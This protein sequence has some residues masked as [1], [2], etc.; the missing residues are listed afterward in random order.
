LMP[1]VPPAMNAVFP[2]NKLSL[3][4]LTQRFSR[5]Y[6]RAATASAR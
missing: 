5:H 1:L 6:R 2:A 3:N 4:A